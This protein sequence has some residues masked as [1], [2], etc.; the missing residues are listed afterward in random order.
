MGF[1]MTE[2]KKKAGRPSKGDDAKSKYVKVRTND[3]EREEWKEKGK[4]KGYDDLSRWIRHL[5]KAA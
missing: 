5:I 1:I 4:E 3:A 2:A